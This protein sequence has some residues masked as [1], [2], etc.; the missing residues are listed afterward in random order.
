M[1]NILPIIFCVKESISSD[2]MQLINHKTFYTIVMLVLCLYCSP[3]QNELM[4][5]GINSYDNQQYRTAIT[6]FTEAIDSDP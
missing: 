4:M 2:R 3:Q 6:Y 5:K 1:S